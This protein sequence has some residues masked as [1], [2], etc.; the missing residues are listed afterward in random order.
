MRSKY[1]LGVSVYYKANYGYGIS[2]G[3]IV[4]LHDDFIRV[5]PEKLLDGEGYTI[6]VKF[7]DVLSIYEK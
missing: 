3:N 5:R 6:T 7:E 2:K 1:S 4:G